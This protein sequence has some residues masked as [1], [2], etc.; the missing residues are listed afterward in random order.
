VSPSTAGS[1]RGRWYAYPTAAPKGGDHRNS[2]GT[3]RL[4]PL[5]DTPNYG[6]R[7]GATLPAADVFAGLV[8]YAK[9]YNGLPL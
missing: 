9:A 1:T 6:L 4:T 8:P 3:L 5:A 2:D 7:A